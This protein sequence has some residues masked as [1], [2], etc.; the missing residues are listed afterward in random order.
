MHE[1]LTNA[2]FVPPA[3]VPSASDPLAAIRRSFGEA[4]LPRVHPA[5]PATVARPRRRVRRRRSA[6]L[7]A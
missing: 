6:A 3:A 1:F 5:V 4:E 7:I 2:C